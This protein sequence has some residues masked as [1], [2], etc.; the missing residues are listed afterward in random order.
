M[1][2]LH[3][4]AP[5]A[6]WHLIFLRLH[7]SLY[8]MLA[9]R[10]SKHVEIVTCWIYQALL[11]RR[12][13]GCFSCPAAPR[14]GAMGVY[15][16]P[17]NGDM[18]GGMLLLWLVRISRCCCPEGGWYCGW[19]ARPWKDPQ[20]VDIVTEMQL[21]WQLESSELQ[22]KL[23]RGKLWMQKDKLSFCCCRYPV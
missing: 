4:R 6:V 15:R 12:F 22:S 23:N 14:R 8:I 17:G 13:S 10:V 19:E 9:G 21:P 11:F 2:F 18:G 7:S 20:G 3:V 5:S 16:I 1:Q